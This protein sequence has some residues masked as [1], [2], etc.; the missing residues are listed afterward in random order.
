MRQATQQVETIE[1]SATP[2]A[3]V[4]PTCTTQGRSESTSSHMIIPTK[5]NGRRIRLPSGS[6]AEYSLRS[7]RVES[8]ISHA[9]RKEGIRAQCRSAMM[10]AFQ[11]SCAPSGLQRRATVS[12]RIKQTACGKMASSRGRPASQYNVVLKE[13]VMF[14]VIYDEHCHQHGR[15]AVS[16]CELA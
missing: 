4:S 7:L 6:M 12:S 5:L 11:C 16:A 13:R 14:H 10:R 8:H 1:I 3:P 15:A 9:G 2:Y